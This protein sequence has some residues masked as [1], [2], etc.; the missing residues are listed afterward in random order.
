MAMAGVPTAEDY[1]AGGQAKE[2]KNPSQEQLQQAYQQIESEIGQM[3]QKIA[4]LDQEKREHELVLVAMKGVPDDRRC[5]RMVGGILAE[6]TVKDVRPQVDDNKGKIEKAIEMFKAKLEE[7]G[8]T[9]KLF[10]EKYNI[11]DPQADKQAAATQATQGN[12]QGSGGGVL[13]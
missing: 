12:N 6:R 5:C 9:R 3:I 1:M 13:V 11:V 2:I 4:D 10:K 8:K 7:K